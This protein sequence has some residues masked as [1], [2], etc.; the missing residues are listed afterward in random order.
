M[1]DSDD[2]SRLY[3]KLHVCGLRSS[4]YRTELL[5]YRTI[6]TDRSVPLARPIDRDPPEAIAFQLMRGSSLC[7]AGSNNNTAWVSGPKLYPHDVSF[8]PSGHAPVESR[9]RE[10]IVRLI[11]WHYSSVKGQKTIASM[12]ARQHNS[13][14]Q[15]LRITGTLSVIDKGP[16]SPSF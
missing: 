6:E 9:V 2:N 4:I 5:G 1:C 8:D 7:Q 16:S 12:Q 13:S 3:T 15:E 10:P 11:A 14:S